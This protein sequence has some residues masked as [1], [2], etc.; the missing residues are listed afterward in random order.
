[1]ISYIDIYDSEYKFEYNKV[2][3]DKNTIYRVFNYDFTDEHHNLKRISYRFSINILF[4]ETIEKL[5]TTN[6][7]KIKS[8]FGDFD[9]EEVSGKKDHLIFETEIY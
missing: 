8:V 5:L 3:L 7:F 4:Q 2:D 6:G 1:M 9:G